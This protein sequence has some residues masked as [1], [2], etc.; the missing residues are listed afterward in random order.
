[1]NMEL[2]QMQRGNKN[3]RKFKEMGAPD[4][5]P[6]INPLLEGDEWVVGLKDKNDVI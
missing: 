5:G 2:K 1:M 6:I 4:N 3:K